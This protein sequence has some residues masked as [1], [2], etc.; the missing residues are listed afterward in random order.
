MEKRYVSIRTLYQEG[1]IAQ[2]AGKTFT[3]EEK[4]ITRRT[5][6]ISST[7]LVDHQEL[8]DT[9]LS[10]DTVSSHSTDGSFYFSP[11]VS[12]LKSHPN[13]NLVVQIS[14]YKDREVSISI[15]NYL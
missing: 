12:T 15:K 11:P 3:S 9:S 1:I 13:E 2:V 4:L 10:D 14:S 7:R 8:E 5:E 6:R